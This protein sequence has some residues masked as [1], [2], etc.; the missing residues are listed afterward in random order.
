MGPGPGMQR[1]FQD[2]PQ[3]GPPQ[4]GQ[5]RQQWQGQPQH[6]RW[7]QRPR[8]DGYGRRPI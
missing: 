6:Q 8:H 4:R 7:Q 5:G 2:R 3:Y 1:W